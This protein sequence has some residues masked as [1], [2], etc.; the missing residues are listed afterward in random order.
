MDRTIAGDKPLTVNE[1]NQITIFER[2]FKHISISKR[3]VSLELGFPYSATQT[4][5]CRNN[6]HNS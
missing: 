3:T 2:I 1:D 6:L 5:L 4:F